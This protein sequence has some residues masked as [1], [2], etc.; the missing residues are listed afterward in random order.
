MVDYIGNKQV[1]TVSGFCVSFNGYAMRKRGPVLVSMF[2]PIGTVITVVISRFLGHT[3][4]IGR[5]DTILM[6]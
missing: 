1:G 3:I 2:N 5:Y 4:V 6:H